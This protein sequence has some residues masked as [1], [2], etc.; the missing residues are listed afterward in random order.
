MN[1]E[2]EEHALVHVGIPP[3]I[4]KLWSL[5]STPRIPHLRTLKSRVAA[6]AG[7]GGT[8]V[9]G[10]GDGKG[11]RGSRERLGS[12]TLREERGL[13]SP[14]LTSTTGRLYVCTGRLLMCVCVG[15]VGIFYHNIWKGIRNM[16]CIFDM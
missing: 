10:A 16:R 4:P 3:H 5:G 1:A 9:A 12:A 14:A 7:P 11:C 8:G 13:C 6:G 15:G 2:K